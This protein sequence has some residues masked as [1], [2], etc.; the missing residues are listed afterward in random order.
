MA[1][2]RIA[3]LEYAIIASRAGELKLNF[4]HN[5]CERSEP[6]AKVSLIMRCAGLFLYVGMFTETS[7]RS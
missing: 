3:L 6:C 5:V 2:D 1:R 7:T 4:A